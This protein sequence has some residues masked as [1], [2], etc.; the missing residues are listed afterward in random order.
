MNKIFYALLAI[1]LASTAC[2]KKGCIDDTA[3][4]YSSSAKQDDGSCTYNTTTDTTTD[5]STNYICDGNGSNQFIPFELGNSWEH[6]TISGPSLS[7][8]TSDSLEI[9]GLYLHKM[10]NRWIF[11]WMLEEYAGYD[12]NGNFVHW[13]TS[14]SFNSYEIFIPANLSIGTTWTLDNF[15]NANIYDSLVVIADDISFTTPDCS[16]TNL[17]QINVYNTSN[18]QLSYTYYMKKGLG[19]VRFVNHDSFVS[20]NSYL[21]AVS[22]N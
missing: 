21:T 7:I 19:V 16:Y 13:G 22:L 20:S 12:A 4:N 8:S 2:K 14:T 9:G 1:S 18:G 11:P 3:T 5:N 6:T 10:T 15:Q 17:T